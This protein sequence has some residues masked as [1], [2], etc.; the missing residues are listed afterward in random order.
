MRGRAWKRQGSS[1]WCERS[2]VGWHLLFLGSVSGEANGTKE[3]SKSDGHGGRGVG[4]VGEAA[5][6]TAPQ[7][8]KGIRVQSIK[9][10]KLT[11]HYI[12]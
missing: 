3:K 8:E 4:E 12:K 6:A 5:G 11:C 9:P 10:V 2:M 7:P 1:G